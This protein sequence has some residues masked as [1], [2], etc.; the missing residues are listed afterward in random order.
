[1]TMAIFET[2]TVDEDTDC[3]YCGYPMYRGDHATFF[4]GEIA[5]VFCS[6]YCA[7]K[8]ES[9]NAARVLARLAAYSRPNIQHQVTEV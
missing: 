1:M 4:E 5:G 9:A 7:M 2:Y 3:E 8:E 6:A